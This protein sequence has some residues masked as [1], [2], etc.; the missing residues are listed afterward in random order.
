[1]YIKR[2]IIDGFVFGTIIFLYRIDYIVF[3]IIMLIDYIVFTI[4]IFLY[5]IDEIIFLFY[6]QTFIKVFMYLL[7][8]SSTLLFMR[9][10]LIDM[11]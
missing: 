3:P 4:I 1:M 2:E 9:Q 5:S 6:N 10:V 11:I 7:I 8:V